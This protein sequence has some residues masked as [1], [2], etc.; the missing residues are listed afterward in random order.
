MSSIESSSNPS[1]QPIQCAKCGAALAVSTLRGLCPSCLAMLVL[2]TGDETRTTLSPESA[3]RELVSPTVRYFGDYELIEEIARGGMGVV[4]RARQVSLNRTVALKMVLSGQLA[5]ALDVKRFYIEAEAAASLDHPNIVPIYEVGAHEG[6]HYF[7]MKLVEGGSLADRLKGG[8]SQGGHGAGSPQG[9]ALSAVLLSTVARAV[10]YAHQRGIL[11]RDLK[12]ANILMDNEGHP[13]ITD[14]GLAKRVDQDSWLTRTEAVMGTPA[15]MAPEQALGKTREISTA[16]DIYSL[17]AILYQ[18]LTGRPVFEG[19][20]PLETLRLVAESDPMPP[21]KLNRGVPQDLETICLKCLEKSPD[22]RYASARELAE[23]IERFLSCEPILARPAGGLRRTWTWSQRNPWVFAAALGLMLL[24]LG[25]IAYGLWEKSRFLSW[26]LAVGPDAK[27]PLGESPAPFFFT[28]FP[29]LCFLLY[30]AGRTFRRLYKRRTETGAGFGNAHLAAHG[31]L[32][33]LGLLFGMGHIQTQIRSW[34]WQI[35]SVPILALELAGVV[36]ALALN[37]MAFRLLWEALGMHETSKFQERVGK[38]LERQVATEAGSWPVGKI[39]ALTVT[40]LAIAV[41]VVQLVNY[42]ISLG[43]RVLLEALSGFVPPFAT[44]MLGVWASRKGRR[45]FLRVFAPMVLGLLGLILSF[46]MVGYQQPENFVTGLLLGCSVSALVLQLAGGRSIPAAQTVLPRVSLWTEALAGACLLAALTVVFYSVENW[47]GHRT[48]HKVQSELAAR[49]ESLDFKTFLAARVKDEENVMAHPFMRKKMIRGTGESPRIEHIKI[50]GM[51]GPPFLLAG[52]KTLPRI[53]LGKP[54]QSVVGV[55]SHGPPVPEFRFT[56]S[57]LAEVVK[58]LADRA[59]FKVAAPELTSAW[60]DLRR[61]ESSRT[62]QASPLFPRKI[63][64]TLTN[65]TP[66]EA[67][68]KVT[69]QFGLVADPIKWREERV[70]RFD[71]QHPSLSQVEESY[72]QFADEFRQLEEALERPKSQLRPR[73]EDLIRT[74]IP[75]YVAFRSFVQAYASRCK[76]QLL[77]GQTDKALHSLKMVRLLGGAVCAN[78]PPT[79]V[80]S[81]IRGAI[82]GLFIETLEETLAEGLWRGDQME[83][84]QKLCEGWDLISKVR[85]GMDGGERAGLLYICQRR[86]DANDGSIFELL[87]L[88]SIVQHGKEVKEPRPERAMR[89]L[90]AWIVPRGWYSQNFALYARQM[91]LSISPLATDGK[92]FDF[93]KLVISAGEFSRFMEDS[94]I[95]KPYRLLAEISIPNFVKAGVTS[96]HNQTR[97]N[98]GTA[99]CA[100]ERYHAARGSYPRDLAELVPDYSS[101]V[102]E[103]VVV[104]SAFKYRRIEGGRY[105]LYSVGGNLRDDGGEAVNPAAAFSGSPAESKGDLVWRS[106]GK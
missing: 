71:L 44:S 11:H 66:V 78:T 94:L 99:A 43:G 25:G 36:C 48:W 15:Y 52:L 4:F 21:S 47:R 23:E 95:P 30:L 5:T 42:G 10:H 57:A 59:G 27:V 7:S 86:V 38:A 22:Q 104:H 103:E 46:L 50:P 18:L 58:T 88:S 62:M 53:D 17:G 56:N 40:N 63:T 34:V 39:V 101:T 97:L 68:A 93:E 29:G 92:H 37:W 73:M 51:E 72:E 98:L 1:S 6:R 87:R 102:P 24:A 32:G 79:L 70:L 67:L 85:L 49:G 3:K 8:S 83:A 33:L 45:P 20:T 13:H 61:V 74:S 76:T 26:R 41:F 35:S 106:V 84:L 2:G 64:L 9:I 14:F 55:T 28:I 75:N 80:E 12:P 54:L 16:S 90:L 96:A 89:Q 82:S 19:G 60:F 100:L 105:L 65:L 31:G 77:L 69:A 91:Q 81:M